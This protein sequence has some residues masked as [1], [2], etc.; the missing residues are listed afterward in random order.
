M[1]EFVWVAAEVVFA[2]HDE[3]LAEH[4]GPAGFRDKGLVESALGSISN[5]ARPQNMAADEGCDDIA[6]LAAAY[7]CGIGK[8]HGFNDG[9][10]RTALVTADTFLY[11][12]G[13]EL[14]SPPTDT[15]FTMLGVADGSLTEDQLVEWFRENVR[16]S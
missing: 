7:A 3:Q 9:N 14:A 5:M 4:G 1:S 11:L 12:N 8:N 13:Y 6:K 2:V 16:A 10:E 15:V